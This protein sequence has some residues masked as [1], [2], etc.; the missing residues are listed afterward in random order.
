M[1]LI[2]ANSPEPDDAVPSE[3]RIWLNR[4]WKIIPSQ[5]RGYVIEG[6]KTMRGL[7]RFGMVLGVLMQAGYFF[8][9]WLL[10]ILGL[11]LILGAWLDYRFN[12]RPPTMFFPEPGEQK[13][14]MERT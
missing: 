7:D 4:G 12:T 9:L 11:V 3:V 5:R 6:Q 8:G 10:G 14:V 2:T 1:A 13:R